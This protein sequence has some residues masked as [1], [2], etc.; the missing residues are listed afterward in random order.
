MNKIQIIKGILLAMIIAF[1]AA[2]VIQPSDSNLKMSTVQDVT[3][4]KVDM[5]DLTKQ[6]NQDIKRF[7]GLQPG[8]YKEIVYYKHNDTMQSPEVLI[9]KFTNHSQQKAF[10]ETMKKHR[11]ERKGVFDGYAPKEAQ[12]L[13][14]SI[15]TVHANYAIF[16]V[17][18]D[19]RTINKQFLSNF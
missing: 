4:K 18:K 19:A 2:N 5:K 1:L 8:D 13:S 14:D 16:I 3:L 7:L 9:V 17:H 12:L 11:D 6:N 15:T 10:V